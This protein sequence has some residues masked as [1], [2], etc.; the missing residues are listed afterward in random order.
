[1]ESKVKKQVAEHYDLLGNPTMMTDSSKMIIDPVCKMQLRPGQIRE[2]LVIEGQP[3]YFC[4]IGCWAEFQRHPEDYLR[5][6][7]KEGRHV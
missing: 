1:M 2:S 5:P 4:S 7:P 3:Y 6:G